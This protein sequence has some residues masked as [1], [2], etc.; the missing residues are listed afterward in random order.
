MMSHLANG[1]WPWVDLNHQQR[2]LPLIYL[3]DGKTSAPHFKFLYAQILVVVSVL[4][5]NLKQQLISLK[6]L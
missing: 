1:Q 2:I 4:T 6:S 5:C 3:L